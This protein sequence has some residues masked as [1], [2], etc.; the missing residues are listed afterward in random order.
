[1]LFRIC[2]LF[3]LTFQL[4]L[5]IAFLI[6]KEVIKIS[7][8]T[9]NRR[10]VFILILILSAIITPTGDPITLFIFAIPLYLFI[11]LAIYIQIKRNKN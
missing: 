6:S 9:N 4:P 11:E 5:F 2:L 10:E 3:G 8:I 7:L 1:M